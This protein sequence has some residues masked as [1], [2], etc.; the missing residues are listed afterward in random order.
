MQ[1]K[2]SPILICPC[3]FPFTISLGDWNCLDKLPTGE[4]VARV[5]P[6]CRCGECNQLLT[7]DGAEDG[8]LRGVNEPVAA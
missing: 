5:L 2:N 8:Y 6:L 3:G 4:E 7:R 1:D